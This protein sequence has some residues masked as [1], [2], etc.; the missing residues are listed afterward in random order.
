MGSPVAQEGL[1]K[2]W[3]HLVQQTPLP[4]L[5]LQEILSGVAS[6]MGSA[7]WVMGL[8]KSP[9]LQQSPTL[10][11]RAMLTLGQ[12]GSPALL[13]LLIEC[14]EDSDFTVRLH[15]VAALKQI[16]PDLAHA[17][18]EQCLKDTNIAPQLAAGLAIALRE[19]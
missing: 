16:D 3:Q 14:L 1:M 10:R 15:V 17:A 6:C 13:P 8:L 12:I 19:W 5:L 4:E 2:V 11:A 7:E 18:M 9:I